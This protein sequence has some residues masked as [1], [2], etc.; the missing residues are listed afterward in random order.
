MIIGRQTRW[1]VAVCLGL[2]AA[3]ANADPH[4]VRVAVLADGTVAWEIET[5]QRYGLDDKHG[6][7][8]DVVRLVTPTA[9]KIALQAD[10]VDV[11]VADWLWVGRQRN[12]GASWTFAPYSRAVGGLVARQNGA[13]RGIAGLDG[14]RIGIVGGPLDKNWLILRAYAMEQGQPDPAGRAQPVYGAPPLM[15]RQLEAGR[16]DMV[17]TYWH[18]AA[19]LE[20]AGYHRVMDVNE[21]TQGLGLSADVPILG[22]VFDAEWAARERAAIDAFLAASREAK[23]RLLRDDEAWQR[24][25]P[26]MDVQD[27][28]EFLALRDGFRD[29]IP[30]QWGQSE[31]AAARALWEI[32]RDYGGRDLV[33]EG[34]TLTPGTFWDGLD[35]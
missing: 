14:A 12:Q 3:V 13:T 31:R 25:R 6:L 5:I 30:R 1:F 24:L 28:A 17:L 35:H 32:L 29:G 18:Y 23:E 15:S 22:Y 19:R 26:S 4:T 34:K 27:E 16:I 10:R 20:A 7:S 21:M 33:G 9:G 11:I 2:C 8:L